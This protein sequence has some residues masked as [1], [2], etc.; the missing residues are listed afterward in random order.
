[1]LLLYPPS[2]KIK[3]RKFVIY[4]TFLLKLFKNITDEPYILVNKIQ[5]FTIKL[6]FKVMS[7]RK[8]FRSSLSTDCPCPGASGTDNR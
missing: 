6:Y 2:P 4:I 5:C 1:M 7:V 8:V 3:K